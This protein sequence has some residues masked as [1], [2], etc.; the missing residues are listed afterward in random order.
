MGSWHFS[1]LVRSHDLHLHEVGPIIGIGIAVLGLAS[2]L[3][4]GTL[5]D[6]LGARDE[7]NRTRLIGT[8]AVATLGIGI[9]SIFTP[10]ANGALA[11]VVVFAAAVVFWFPTVAALTQSLVAPRMRAT[12]AGLLFVL[13]NLVGYG[14]GPILV[15]TISDL[16]APALGEHS[17]RYAMMAVLSLTAWAA[18][19]FFMASRDLRT[20]LSSA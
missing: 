7:R 8:A 14:I 11:G 12:V 9:W 17:L 16:L 15:G 6:F 18:V 3:L 13:S 4:S 10:S 1:F 5:S 20:N 2:N 19:H